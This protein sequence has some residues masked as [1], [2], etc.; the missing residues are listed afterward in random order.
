MGALSKHYGDIAI[1]VEK[2][3]NSV[4]TPEQLNSAK[5]LLRNAERWVNA[6]T[7]L[8]FFERQKLFQNAEIAFN[9]KDRKL[10]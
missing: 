10:T 7:K 8:E 6:H 9:I 5:K 4:E 1:W 2:V 3:I